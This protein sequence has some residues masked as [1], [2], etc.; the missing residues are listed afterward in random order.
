M[1]IYFMTTQRP[2]TVA[3]KLKKAAYAAGIELKLGK[4]QNAVA[5]MY[6][7]AHWNELHS[8]VGSRTPSLMDGDV[9]DEEVTVTLPP[10]SIQF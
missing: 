2:K 6:G 7:Y 9:A 4:A 10:V 5:R 3:K 1:R 8:S